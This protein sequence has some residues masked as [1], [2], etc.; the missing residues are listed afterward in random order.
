MLTLKDLV[1]VIIPHVGVHYSAK[2]DNVEVV[3]SD[4]KGWRVWVSETLE[5]GN[6][7]FTC[8]NPKRDEGAFANYSTASMAISKANRYL[9][10]RSFK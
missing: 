4:A 3:G 5:N 6:V 8:I 7:R 1:Q 2:K 9:L 10:R